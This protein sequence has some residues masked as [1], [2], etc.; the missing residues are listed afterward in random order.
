[1]TLSRVCHAVQG[2]PNDQHRPCTGCSCTCHHVT[3]PADF[4]ALVEARKAEIAREEE[5]A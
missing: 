4:R 2:K 1:V 5:T 3:P